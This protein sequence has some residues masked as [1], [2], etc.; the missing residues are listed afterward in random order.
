MFKFI[1]IISCL[2]TVL[3]TNCVANENNI[4]KIWTVENLCKINS[5]DILEEQGINLIKWSSESFNGNK[6]F[7]IEGQWLT[8]VGHYIVECELPFGSNEASLTLILTKS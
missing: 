7:N 5:Y 1:T 2:Y 3:I 6:T 4:T 8:N